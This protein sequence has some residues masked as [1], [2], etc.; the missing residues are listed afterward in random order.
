MVVGLSPDWKMG[1]SRA[2][3]YDAQGGN[4]KIGTL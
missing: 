1:E 4:E 3:A 2:H